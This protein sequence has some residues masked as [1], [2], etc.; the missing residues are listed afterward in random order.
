MV[1]QEMVWFSRNITHITHQP[2][3]AF[4]V[5]MWLNPSGH[6]TK[7]AP[8]NRLKLDFEETTSVLA[9]IINKLTGTVSKV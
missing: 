5:V 9:R 8:L 4:L 6:V 7:H 3:D 1:F 2:T